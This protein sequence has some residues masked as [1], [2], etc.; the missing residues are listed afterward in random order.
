MRK[1]LF[2][3]TSSLAL[4]VPAAAQDGVYDPVEGPRC[5]DDICRTVGYRA[6]LPDREI[7]V[8]ATGE[9]SPITST[10][11]AVTV[12]DLEEIESVQG[13]DITRVLER[14]PGV[15]ITRNGG[16]GAT[17][18]VRVRGSQAEQVLVLIDGVRVA[19]PAAPGGGYDFGNLLPGNLEKIE[20]LRGSNSVIWGSQA[21]GGVILAETARA[22]SG[23]GGSLSAE[24]GARDTTYI[25]GDIGF[26]TRDYGMT[27]YGGYY[28]TDGFS[29]AAA[30][31]EDDAFRQYSAG[32]NAY[33]AITDFATLRLAG[34]YSDGALEFDFPPFDTAD[35]QDTIQ[36]SGSAA[37]DLTFEALDV[38][39]S[40]S[41]ADT[42]RENDGAFGPFGFD[43]YNE[44]IDL[45]A[46]GRLTD[47]LTLRA[48]GNV[49]WS[50][51]AST[52]DT[53]ADEQS[54]AAYTQLDYTAGGVH[55]AAGVRIDD[56]DSFGSEVSFGAD[57]SW[58]F[59]PDVR[60]RASF[61][62]GY[63]APTLYQLFGGFV[64]NPALEA[65]RS[66]SFDIGLDYGSGSDPVFA[67]VT[68]FRRDIENQIE[69]DGSF[70]YFNIAEVRAQ[71]VELELGVRPGERFEVLAAYTYLDTKN[72]TAGSAF[73]GNVLARRPDHALTFSA[74]WEVPLGRLKL[75]GDI[76]LVGD[77]FDRADNILRLDGYEMVTLRAALPVGEKLELFGR[78][79]NLFDEQY[80]TA[81]GY[82]TA[83]RGG[84][85]GVRARF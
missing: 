82:G 2:L 57:A 48:G 56:Y 62:E 15:T 68:A 5:V 25:S 64:G 83:G 22:Q 70:V 72:R 12:I 46:A 85:A 1:Y 38:S 45:R 54:R 16:V 32:V 4:G 21:I 36:Y 81:A 74:D 52:F 35:T 37:L 53:P 66:S 73:E 29:A 14:A 17:T 77:S 44:R 75:G 24:Y 43:G 58:Q 50:N 59:A 18:S 76:R 69:F 6:K 28:D 30:G 80:Q 78:I 55:L 47:A 13:E 63:K 26:G 41:L 79:E 27:A 20:I 31:T 19:D 61:G 71:G 49:E 11:Q 8:T 33:A 10:G 34:R 39:A 9:P 3:L 7:T 40:Y 42:E 65:E 23:L 84:F 60:A 51:F 67:S